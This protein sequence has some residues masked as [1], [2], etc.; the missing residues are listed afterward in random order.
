MPATAIGSFQRGLT[1]KSVVVYV[2]DGGDALAEVCVE[3]AVA[4]QDGAFFHRPLKT[5]SRSATVH[6][7]NRK[8]LP[9]PVTPLLEQ[10][11]SNLNLV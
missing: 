3:G 6:A 11:R 8:E 2:P 9:P 7:G 5:A 1:L 10:G 4:A